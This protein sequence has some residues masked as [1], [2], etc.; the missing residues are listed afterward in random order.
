MQ[1]LPLTGQPI[2][3]VA[4]INGTVMQIIYLIRKKSLGKKWQ[5]FAKIF[6]DGFFFT[7]K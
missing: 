4:I 7:D 2:A 3:N 5:I 1:H 6:A